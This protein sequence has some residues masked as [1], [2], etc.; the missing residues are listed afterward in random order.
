MKI[1]KVV[2]I[3]SIFDYHSGKQPGIV[4][5]NAHL[6]LNVPIFYPHRGTF[7]TLRHVKCKCHIVTI[8]VTSSVWKFQIRISQRIKVM[9]M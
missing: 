3:Y 7:K 9:G 4:N 6:P 2:T 8:S 1:D 5:E